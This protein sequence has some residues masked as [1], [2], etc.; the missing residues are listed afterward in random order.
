MAASCYWIRCSDNWVWQ[1]LTCSPTCIMNI[2][3]WNYKKIRRNQSAKK[4]EK[5][6]GVVMRSV[7]GGGS[8]HYGKD[9]CNTQVSSLEWNTEEVNDTTLASCLINARPLPAHC[10][11][12]DD[13]SLIGCT[14]HDVTDDWSL[15]STHFVDSLC[16]FRCSFGCVLLLN[17]I[18]LTTMYRSTIPLQFIW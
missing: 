13:N 10:P 11:S 2:K 7:W 14:G 4:S 15:A 5:K 18:Y 17:L 6:T 3:S 8:V 16:L 1:S 9:L 12:A